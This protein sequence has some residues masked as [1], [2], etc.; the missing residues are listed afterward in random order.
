MEEGVLLYPCLVELIIGVHVSVGVVMV[1]GVQ[2]SVEISC[3][4]HLLL[5]EGSFCEQGVEIGLDLG[6]DLR[7]SGCDVGTNDEN[8]PRVC[9]GGELDAGYVPLQ[10]RWC[11]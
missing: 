7:V 11:V 6:S 1:L 4:D 5:S 2:S 10:V 8:A 9:D 3:Y